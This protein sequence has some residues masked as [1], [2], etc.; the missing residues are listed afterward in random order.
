MCYC[1]LCLEIM[2]EGGGG[3]GRWVVVM[4]R[5]CGWYCDD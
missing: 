1:W 4:D 3:V 5:F 2:E